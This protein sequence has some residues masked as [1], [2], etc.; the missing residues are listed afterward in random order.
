MWARW[1]VPLALVLVVALITRRIEPPLRQLAL[2]LAM[3]GT[4]LL[5]TRLRPFVPRAQV[6]LLGAAAL[7]VGTSERGALLA[8]RM[9]PAEA[10]ETVVRLGTGLG[11]GVASAFR[12]GALGQPGIRPFTR[13]LD[14]VDARSTENVVLASR[15]AAGCQ[16]AD[17][18]CEAST[19]LRFV[20]D[21]VAYRTDPRGGEDYVKSPQE[22]LAANAGDCEDKSILLV[23]LL[24]AIGN[25]TWLVFTREHV[26]PMACF[27]TPLPELW[28]RRTARLAPEARAAYAST[29]WPPRGGSVT[30]A[31]AEIERLLETAESIEIDDRNCYAVEPTAAGSYFGA[32]H[33]GRDYLIAIDPIA[34]AAIDL[35]K[36]GL[37]VTR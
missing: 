32:R 3:M 5:S 36:A 34:R 29:L 7:L 28:R 22:T 35:E 26:W 17:R 8:G 21:E 18:L 20:A 25:R 30:P 14:R 4:L 6:V 10:M 15:V 33:E 13:Y 19:L 9:A 1:I 37:P 31:P 12:V 2:Y 16:S 23:S 27:D 24:E 11:G